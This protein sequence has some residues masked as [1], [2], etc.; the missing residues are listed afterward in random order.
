[1][2]VIVQE[3]GSSNVVGGGVGLR[4]LD[5]VAG[6]VGGEAGA[7]GGAGLCEISWGHDDYALVRSLVQKKNRRNQQ[8]RA[9]KKNFANNCLLKHQVSLAGTP[10]AYNLTQT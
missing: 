3:A 8:C 9:R 1:M 7:G 6:D 2:A 5:G 10:T 4:K